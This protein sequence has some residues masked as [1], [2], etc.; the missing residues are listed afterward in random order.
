MSNPAPYT[1]PPPRADVKAAAPKKRRFLEGSS[2][3]RKTF[4]ITK[5]FLDYFPDATAA[6]AEVSYCGNAKHNPGE[7]LHWAR[8]KSMDHADCMARHLIERGG[9][10]IMVVDGVEHK[11]RHSAALAW[12]A[13]A[14]L[15]QELE[16][17][18]GLDAP[19]GARDLPRR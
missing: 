15:Q 4:P 11:M 18:M 7:D 6:V 3:E 8:S 10:E 19:R 16:A 17:E 9:F 1:P 5:G 13:M 12:R 2:G 14:S